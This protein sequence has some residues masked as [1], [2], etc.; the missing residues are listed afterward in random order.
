MGKILLINDDKAVSALLQYTLQQRGMSVDVAYD[1]PS[2]MEQAMTAEYDLVLLDV[3]MPGMNGD[4]VC[5]NLRNH[6]QTKELPI[7]LISSLADAKKQ[8]IVKDAHANGCID[9][10]SIDN[11]LC[12]N[13]EIVM[14]RYT[15]PE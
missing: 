7:Y 11:E 9:I 5:K 15:H 2:G 13:I 3:Y 10:S 12:K 4:V 14:S 1:G 6:E 8:E